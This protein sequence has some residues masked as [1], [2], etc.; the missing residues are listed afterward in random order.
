[1]DLVRREAVEREQHAVDRAA[2]E[3]LVDVGGRHQHRDGLQLLQHQLLRRPRGADLHPLDVLQVRE[4]FARDDLVRRQDRGEEQADAVRCEL[5]LV[6]HAARLGEVP[7]RDRS[8]ARAAELERQLGDDRERHLVGDESRRD[9]G[10]VDDP[11]LDERQE[12]LR[13]AHL[14]GRVVLELESLRGGVCLQPLDHR[15][16][17]VAR[18][19][20]A[21]R[22][23]VGDLD[24]GRRLRVRDAGE[25]Q[26]GDEGERGFAGQLVH[27]GI[28]SG[29]DGVRR[30]ADQGAILPGSQRMIDGNATSM[31]SSIR[32]L[33]T[34]GQT[35]A[36]I[37]CSGRLA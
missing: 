34:C 5:L 1:M 27:V 19:V 12:V 18:Q 2:R 29:V 20:V 24:L 14:L 31:A 23:R 21:D 4:G 6:E 9:V 8:L 35:P 7:V 15:R 33:K 11:G 28:L 16:R 36:K 32:W 25:A 30:N 26:G 3:R 37:S 17:D 13:L 10:D 22:E